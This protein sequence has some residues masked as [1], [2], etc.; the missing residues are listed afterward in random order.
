MTYT[1]YIT[2]N[3]NYILS[4]L[5]YAEHCHKLEKEREQCV[6]N[7]QA[8]N[9]QVDALKKALEEHQV[10]LADKVFR[11][12]ANSFTQQPCTHACTSM[13][14]RNMSWNSVS[15][16]PEKRNG[17]NLWALK[18]QKL[19]WKRGLQSCKGTC[20]CTTFKHLKP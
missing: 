7:W 13:S 2:D 19:N 17:R 18:K 10:L 14:I 1:M 4:T 16:P 9:V 20:T 3:Y 12:L 6:Q 11:S 5:R 8:G 15:N